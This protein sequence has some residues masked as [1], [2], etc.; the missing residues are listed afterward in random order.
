LN[1][2]ASIPD[3]TKVIIDTN[4]ILYTAL[5]HPAFQQSCTAFLIRVESEEIKG[6]IPSV[7]IQ[8]I[9]HHFIISEL[10]EKGYGKSVTDC[11]A[12]YKRDPH[13]M[14]E[15]SKTWIEI[16]R[17]FKINC[18]ILYDNPET[19]RDSIPISRNFQLFTKDAYIAS[20]AQFYKIS[21]IA[22]NDKDFSRVPW[23]SVWKP[24]HEYQGAPPS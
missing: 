24:Q 5:N 15:L 16:Q 1:E 10:M 4:I 13:I 19:M 18:T 2:L 3:G 21:H 7:V 23:L 12:H 17:I 20:C 14:N 6:F 8:E 9:S 22:S 11:I